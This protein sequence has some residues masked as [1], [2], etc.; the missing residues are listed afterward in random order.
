MKSISQ[1]IKEC[2][3]ENQV[4]QEA[5]ETYKTKGLEF[6]TITSLYPVVALLKS[7]SAVLSEALKQEELNTLYHI[8]YKTEYCYNGK[9]CYVW[10]ICKFYEISEN[11]Q[12]QCCANVNQ[13]FTLEKLNSIKYDNS[14]ITKCSD[15]IDH[16][17]I[18]SNDIKRVKSYLGIFKVSL[19]KIIKEAQPNISIEL[20]QKDEFYDNGV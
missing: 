18:I 7:A 9:L 3:N 17:E 2:F 4:F 6:Y 19:L 5:L 16:N 8:D 11:N 12:L 1:N 15:S 13:M 10:I 20:R 14:Y